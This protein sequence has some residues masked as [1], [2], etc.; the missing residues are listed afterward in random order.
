MV[1][2]F[3][4][5]ESQRDPAIRAALIHLIQD[6]YTQRLVEVLERTAFELKEKGWTVPMIAD[7][8]C[9]SVAQTRRAISQYARRAGRL[10]PL[11][12]RDMSNVIDIR[13][14]VRKADATHQAGEGTTHPTA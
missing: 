5:L 6:E 2:V 14:L 4:P 10:S 7:E 9:I 11:R 12:T 8:L 13:S 3:V 1:E